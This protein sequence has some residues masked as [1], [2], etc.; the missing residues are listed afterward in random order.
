[1]QGDRVVLGGP[2]EALQRGG[3]RALTVQHARRSSAAGARSFDDR[4][5]QPGQRLVAGRGE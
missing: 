3:D 2:D 5:A 4:L 1:V